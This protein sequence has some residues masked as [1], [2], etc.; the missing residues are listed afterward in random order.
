MRRNK[1]N[2]REHGCNFRRLKYLSHPFL[3]ATLL[4]EL[5]QSHLCSP[6]TADSGGFAAMR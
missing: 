4:I 5:F 1:R 3:P 2:A 6:A